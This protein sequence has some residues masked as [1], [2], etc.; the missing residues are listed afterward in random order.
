MA[1]TAKISYYYTADLAYSL[2]ACQDL[3]VLMDSLAIYSLCGRIMLDS[4]A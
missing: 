4:G 3:L 1:E 2:A